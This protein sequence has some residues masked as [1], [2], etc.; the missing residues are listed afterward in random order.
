MQPCNFTRTA[1]ADARVMGGSTAGYGE[2][3]LNNADQALCPIMNYGLDGRSCVVKVGQQGGT[4]A[5]F[6]VFIDG[7]IEQ[8]EVSPTK[9]TLRLRDKLMLLSIPVQQNLYLGNN[10]LPNGQEGNDDLTGQPKPLLYGRVLYAPT[11]L[12]NSALAIT[13]VHDGLSPASMVC[14]MAVCHHFRCQLS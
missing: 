5:S 6:T 7:T 8:C 9:V 10:V 11:V 12:V 13:K 1:F 3:V 14:S 2:I 4:Y